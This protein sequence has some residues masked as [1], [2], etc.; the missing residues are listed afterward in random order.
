MNTPE[1][2]AIK[3]RYARRDGAADAQLYSLYGNAAALQA[4]QERVRA[5]RQIWQGY[6]WNTLA[7]KHIL[8][9]G[10]GAAGNLQDL[11]RLGATPACLAGIELI[12]E[13]AETARRLLPEGASILEGDAA[14]ATIAPGSQHAVLAFTLFSSLMDVTFRRALAQTMWQWVAPGGG[15]LVYDFT[16]NNPRNADVQGVP[17]RELA[18]LFPQARLQS[19][20]LTLAPPIAR[21]L[22]PSLIG[23]ASSTLFLLRTHRLTWAVKP[24]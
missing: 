21:R 22:P 4:Q 5:M 2:D 8:E 20:R 18:A 14:T 6:G 7:Q 17:L 10:C 19:R 9:V 13:R 16:V 12:R 24:L 1:P 23:F 15:I 3:A 11:V